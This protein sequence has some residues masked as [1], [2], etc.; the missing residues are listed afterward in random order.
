MFTLRFHKAHSDWHLIR[1]RIGLKVPDLEELFVFFQGLDQNPQHKQKSLPSALFCW[2]FV[3]SS[4]DGQIDWLPFGERNHTWLTRHNSSCALVFS[5]HRNH[6]TPVSNCMDFP[7]LASNQYQMAKKLSYDCKRAQ[8]T[9]IS[10]KMLFV[11]VI[12]PWLKNVGFK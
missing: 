3:V 11:A 6:N 2:G 8:I 9:V 5:C 1:N 4:S 7:E 10:H 12:F